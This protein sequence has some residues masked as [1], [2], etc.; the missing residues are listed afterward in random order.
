MANF[1]EIPCPFC[2]RVVRTS[3]KFCIFCGSK[4]GEAKTKKKHKEMTDTEREELNKELGTG[5]IDNLKVPKKP[6]QK[7]SSIPFQVLEGSQDDLDDR[8][9][10]SEEIDKEKKS[11][12]EKKKSKSHVELPEEIKD[13]LEAKMNLAVIENKKKRLK[14]KLQELTDDIE[15]ERYEYDMEFAQKLNLKLNA[16]KS[17]KEELLKEE[18][19]LRAELGPSGQFRVDELDDEMEIQR[20]RLIDLKRS[21]KNHQVKRDV[22]EEL[23]LEYSTDFRKAEDEVQELR[24]N[25][26]RWLSS[27]KA[28]KNQIEKRIRLLQARFKTKEIDS[29]EFETQKKTFEKDVE[30]FTQRIKILEFYSRSKKSRWFG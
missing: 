5:M 16:F 2:G 8:V 10:S 20:E 27:E 3:D 14:K 11:K 6:S 21:F 17:V 18:D 9:L 7:D 22:Y 29:E 23:K 24:V 25:I 19:Q 1:K 4:L 15:S 13:Q 12:K 26:I 28:K 30:Q